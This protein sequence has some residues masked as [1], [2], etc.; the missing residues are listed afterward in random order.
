[1]GVSK[2]LKPPWG[3]APRRPCH[4]A[5]VDMRP[6]YRHLDTYS[7]G[8]DDLRT[9]A[10]I[11]VIA[12]VVHGN[13]MVVRKTSPALAPAGTVPTTTHQYRKRSVTEY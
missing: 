11:L 8:F 6:A 7:A 5:G 10:F 1:M 13:E 2:K 4:D 9:L 3:W 12:V